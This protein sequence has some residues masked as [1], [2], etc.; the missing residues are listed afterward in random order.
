[1]PGP[2]PRTTKV[3]GGIGVDYSQ[4]MRLAAY[5][6]PI[7]TD[8]ANQSESRPCIARLASTSHRVY[9]ARGRRS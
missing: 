2:T 3:P 6:R 1:M 7:V 8:S 9:A 4:I 5:V